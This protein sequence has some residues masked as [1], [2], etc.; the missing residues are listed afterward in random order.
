M[1][2]LRPAFAGAAGGGVKRREKRTALQPPYIGSGSKCARVSLH[3]D[4]RANMAAKRA[5]PTEP[6]T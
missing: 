3:A 2:A 6:I 5:Y 4:T 1:G